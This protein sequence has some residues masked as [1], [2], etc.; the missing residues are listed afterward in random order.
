GYT[1]EVALGT[2]IGYDNP[3]QVGNDLLA[4]QA[5]I[6]MFRAVNNV[7]PNLVTGADFPKQPGYD[8][9][10]FECKKEKKKEEKKKKKKENQKK[11][12][13]HQPQ[14][15]PGTPPQPPGPP[16]GDEGGVIFPPPGHGGGG[17]G[18]GHEPGG[19]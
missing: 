9:K 15:N 11:E 5:W 18:N 6:N 1:P 16:G 3:R 7:D 13:P 17:P 19:G 10:C 4:K 8:V 12:P 2:W 14:P